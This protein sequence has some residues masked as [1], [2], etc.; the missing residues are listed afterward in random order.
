MQLSPK[1]VGLWLFT[2]AVVYLCTP[3]QWIKKNQDLNEAQ[4][5][6]FNLGGFNKNTEL[7][8]LELQPFYA[9]Y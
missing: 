7:T 8:V 4:T 3:Q 5:F 1:D 9:Q 2:G 6:S